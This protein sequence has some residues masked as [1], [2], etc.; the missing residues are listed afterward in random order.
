MEPIPLTDVIKTQDINIISQ[1]FQNNLPTTDELQLQSDDETV[2]SFLDSYRFLYSGSL[3]DFLP[4]YEQKGN[5]NLMVITARNYLP[6]LLLKSGE[7]VPEYLRIKNIEDKTVFN[8]VVNLSVKSLLENVGNLLIYNREHLDEPILIFDQNKTVQQLTNYGMS[9]TGIESIDNRIPNAA[10]NW[11]NIFDHRLVIVP[12]FDPIDLYILKQY[13]QVVY[14]VDEG[15][16]IEYAVYDLTVRSKPL[17]IL[18]PRQQNIT[19]TPFGLTKLNLL[20]GKLPSYGTMSW[21]TVNSPTWVKIP[22]QPGRSTDQID[23]LIQIEL[24]KRKPVT[25]IDI[26]STNQDIKPYSG[27][28][29]GKYYDIMNKLINKLPQ[30]CPHKS[31]SEIVLTYIPHELNKTYTSSGEKIYVP[32][33]WDLEYSKF[34]PGKSHQYLIMSDNSLINIYQDVQKCQGNILYYYI[35]SK[36]VESQNIQS[37][38]YNIG[39]AMA[40]IVDKK[41]KI[42]E[43]FDPSGIT[44]GTKHVY[45]WSKILIRYLKYKTGDEWYRIISSDDIFCPQIWSEMLYNQLAKVGHC[46]LWTFYYLWLRIMNPDVDREKLLEHMSQMYPEQM[47]NKILSIATLLYQ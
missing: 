31:K 12:Y 38:F 28:F 26:L 22:F 11:W 39:H 36:Q 42:I 46:S 3:T 21:K 1:W 29:I 6:L 14:P 40:L 34:I 33:L 9:F 8:Y 10:I 32:Y 15:K 2:N 27:G 43:V 18:K 41:H 37:S 7:I 24:D 13:I 17:F 19:Y 45:R 25:I 4:G 44:P 16:E 35:M 5:T 30:D 23:Q 20:S 47:N